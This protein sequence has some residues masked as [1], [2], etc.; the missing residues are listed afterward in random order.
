VVPKSIEPGRRLTPGAGQ[1]SVY[2]DDE[3]PT[4]PGAPRPE[5]RWVTLDR[6]LANLSPE[7]RRRFVMHADNWF[8]CDANDR[9]LVEAF[10]S[11]CART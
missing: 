8:M 2:V 11:R 1:Y 10:A 3:E 6:L 4:R 7:E 5:D 9:A